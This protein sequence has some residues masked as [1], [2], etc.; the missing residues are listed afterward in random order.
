[1]DIILR[2]QK[3]K[4]VYNNIIPL[5]PESAGIISNPVRIKIIELLAQKPMYP[6][7]LAEKLKMHEQ[8]VYYHIKQLSNAGIISVI[9]KKEIKGT[10]AKKYKPNSLNFAITLSKEWQPF[11]IEKV[12]YDKNET[13]KLLSPFMKNDVLDAIIVVGSPEPHGQFKA[14]A[15]DGHYAIDLGIFVGN[16]CELPKKFS[17]KLDVD[18]K[19]EKEEKNNLIIIGGPGP[20][21]LTYEIN[22][23]LPVKFDIKPAEE[24]FY[25]S[26]L[27]ST[28]TGRKISDD[29]VGVIELIRN[30][31]EK[32]K[33]ILLIAGYRFSGTKSAVIAFTRFHEQLTQKLRNLE[34]FYVIVKGF[35]LDGDGKI[36]SI[37]IIE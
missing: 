19:T 9:E 25:C 18:I 32:S 35:D 4:Y 34:E 23:Y 36:D 30:P 16:Y 21:M 17:V 29:N 15:R 28:K 37:E 7:E 12:K 8:K 20:N 22:N 31:F 14:Y 24:G 3:D 5:N 26:G 1:M 2:R 10:I 13:N 33:Y 27:L 11:K 6:A